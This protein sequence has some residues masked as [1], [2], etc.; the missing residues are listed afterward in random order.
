MKAAR[1]Q[2]CIEVHVPEPDWPSAGQQRVSGA[3]EYLK[4]KKQEMTPILFSLK[5]PKKNGNR[6]FIGFSG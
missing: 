6:G 1:K 4:V 5:K 2:R 3:V